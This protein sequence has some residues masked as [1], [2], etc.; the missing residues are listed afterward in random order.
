[1]SGTLMCYNVHPLSHFLQ[2]CLLIV[3]TM[4]KSCGPS[5]QY[6]ELK[7]AKMLWWLDDMSRGLGAKLKINGSDI[8]A[9]SY[10]RIFRV[11]L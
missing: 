8:G 3:E 11:T 9:T 4:K 1:M 10:Q 2:N 5:D 7:D 6:N